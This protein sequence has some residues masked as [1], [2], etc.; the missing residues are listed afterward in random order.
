MIVGNI[1][2]NVKRIISWRRED[3]NDLATLRAN[4]VCQLTTMP[5]ESQESSIRAVK[6]IDKILN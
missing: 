1:H 3:M 2:K 6:E 5:R 4:L